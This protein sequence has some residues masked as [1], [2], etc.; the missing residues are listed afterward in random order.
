M[1]CYRVTFYNSG[2]YK[3]SAMIRTSYV[4]KMDASGQRQVIDKGQVIG[5]DELIEQLLNESQGWVESCC[6]VKVEPQL[7]EDS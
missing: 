1:N 6:V 2:G 4:L 5:G 3:S 7:L